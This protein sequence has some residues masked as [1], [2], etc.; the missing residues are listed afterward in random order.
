MNGLPDHGPLESTICESEPVIWT[1]FRV[2]SAQL[3]RHIS[4]VNAAPLSD[5]GLTVHR[6]CRLL[7]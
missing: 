1:G 6:F 4:L 5:A 3:V 2:P 7:A